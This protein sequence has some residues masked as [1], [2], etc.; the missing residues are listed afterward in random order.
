MP[1]CTVLPHSHSWLPS[2]GGTLL[3]LGL[4]FGPQRSDPLHGTSLDQ[5]GP[6]R[7]HGEWDTILEQQ[8]PEDIQYNTICTEVALFCPSR[9]TVVSGIYYHSMPV[10]DHVEFPTTHEGST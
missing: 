2:S 3:T 8:L 5:G 9:F 1:V 6:G 4:E 10:L 7:L